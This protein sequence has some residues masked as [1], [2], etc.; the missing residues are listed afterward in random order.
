MRPTMLHFRSSKE[1]TPL[2]Y[3]AVNTYDGRSF[4][5]SSPKGSTKLPNF[6]CEKRF[7]AYDILAKRT[8]FRVGPG[9]YSPELYRP[10]V[11]SG[12]P[13]KELHC[14]RNTKNNGYYMVGNC[15]EFDPNLMLKTSKDMQREKNLR[16]DT[17]YLAE[18]HSRSATTNKSV[19]FSL[20]STRE[21]IAFKKTKER[22]LSPKYGKKVNCIKVHEALKRRFKRVSLK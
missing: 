17:T 2:S 4:N 16:L 20:K 8:G 7:I 6:S 14:Q 15:I 18:K 21:D 1:K 11:R 13:Y 12:S 10:K 19:N 9:S 5:L 22:S 3:D